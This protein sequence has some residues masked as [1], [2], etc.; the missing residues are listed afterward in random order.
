MIRY[1]NIMRQ[2]IAGEYEDN[3]GT[4]YSLLK[5]V[6]ENGQ[7][8][9]YVCGTGFEADTKEVAEQ[10]IMETLRAVKVK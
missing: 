6:Y 5:R 8:F 9:Y 10:Y 2:D 1:G 4:S 3:S 7:T